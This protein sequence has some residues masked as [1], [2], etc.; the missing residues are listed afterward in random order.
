VS[1]LRR[2]GARERTE[3]AIH[4]I[5][6]KTSAEIVVVMRR[7]SGHYLYADLLFGAITALLVLCVFLYHPAEF[8]FTWFPLE[9]A[10]A[11]VLGAVLCAHLP[12]LRRVFVP[13]KLRA[14]NVMAA[15]RAAFVEKNVAKT[16]GRTGLLVYVSAFEHDAFVVA[17]VG[18]EADK[19]ALADARDAIREAARSG[20]VDDFVAALE[21]LGDRLADV[22]PVSPDDVDELD[23]EVAA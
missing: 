4:A 22:H 23:D 18:L 1:E 20:S 19:L 5:E 15:A 12:P 10:A 9:Q 21:K 6:A 13:A 16:R 11:F 14:E 7:A 17:D 2:E 8:D 3:K